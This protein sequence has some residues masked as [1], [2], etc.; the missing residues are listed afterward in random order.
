VFETVTDKKVL[1]D[2]SRTLELHHIQGSPHDAG[3]LMAYLPQDRILVEVDAYA[4]AANARRPQRLV[5]S[6]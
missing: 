6:R 4:P 5:H 3:F 2:G 1:T